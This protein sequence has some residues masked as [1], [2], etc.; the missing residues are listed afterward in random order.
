MRLP[1]RVA[2]FPPCRSA[3]AVQ[4]ATQDGA[5]A[6]VGC[7]GEATQAGLGIEG[8]EKGSH[9]TKTHALTTSAEF[10]CAFPVQRNPASP[11]P[12]P[13]TL[14][15]TI[16]QGFTL[17]GAL[18]CRNVPSYEKRIVRAFGGERRGRG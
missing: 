12:H 5:G 14:A 2:A 16:S 17:F 1:P 15:A 10:R 8:L 7:G 9:P 3:G 18:R 13:H 6:T 4:C 11:R